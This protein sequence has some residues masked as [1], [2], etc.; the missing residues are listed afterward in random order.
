MYRFDVFRS[1]V[2]DNEK[3]FSNENTNEFCDL[4]SIH[5]NFS[6]VIYPQSNGQVEAVNKIITVTQKWQLDRYKEKWVDE[7]LKVL[8]VYTTTSRTMIGET[9]FSMEYGV[10]AL[11]PVEVFV[12]TSQVTRYDKVKNHECMGLELD[13]LKEKHTAA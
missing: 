10:E 5:K 11:L 12:P 13:L 9:S 1:L 6:S 8:W 2:S 7:L 4:L 3:Q